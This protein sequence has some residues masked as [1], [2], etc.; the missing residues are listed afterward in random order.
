MEPVNLPIEV[1]RTGRTGDL[2]TRLW[3]PSTARPMLGCPDGGQS[4]VRHPAS[5]MLAL[6]VVRLEAGLVLL[7]VDYTSARHALGPEQNLALRAR[8]GPAG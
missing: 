2:G 8:D 1:S 4:R 6:D 3:I 5:E 7:E